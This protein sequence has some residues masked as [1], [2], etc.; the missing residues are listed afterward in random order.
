MPPLLLEPSK[1]PCIYWMYM[2]FN[3]CMET[4]WEAAL[5]PECQ[6]SRYLSSVQVQPL[7]HTCLWL[8]GHRVDDSILV[9]SDAI[10][11]R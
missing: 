6:Y 1:D 5:M 3:F 11:G 4:W 2:Y 7:G 10:D 9:T 8:L